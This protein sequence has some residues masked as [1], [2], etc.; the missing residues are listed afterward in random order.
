MPLDDRQRAAALDTLRSATGD[1]SP[2]QRAQIAE[3]LK[4]RAAQGAPSLSTGVESPVNIWRD[5]RGIPHIKAQSLHDLFFAH[6]YVQAQD[7][8]WQLDFLRRQA[9][10]RLSELF[11]ESKL[12]EDRIAHTLRIPSIA[13]Q[14]Y[15][16]SSPESR[17]ETRRP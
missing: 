7:R 11:G 17:S 13:Q 5:G 8:L 14:I 15:E 10:G 2:E 3:L 1:I 6:G 9:R 16:T 4:E 12:S